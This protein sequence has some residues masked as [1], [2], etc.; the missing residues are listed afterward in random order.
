LKS[1][2]YA[3][4]SDRLFAAGFICAT[5]PTAYGGKDWTAIQSTIFAEE[6]FRAGVPTVTRGMGET[7]AGPAIMAH[8]TQEQ[9]DYFLPRIISGEDSYCQGFSEP[10]AGSDLAAVAARGVIEGDEI[11]ITGQKVWTSGF[12]RANMIFIL[13]RTDPDAPKHKGISYVLLPFTKENGIDMMPIRMITGDAEFGEEFFEGARAPLFNVIGGLNNGWTVAMG[14]LGHERTGAAT[15][16]ANRLEREFWA[17]VERARGLGRAS[18]PVV[19]QQLAWAY[20]TVQTIKYQGLRV[21]AQVATGR[22]P[23]PESSLTKVLWSEYEQRF[24]EIA[25]AIEGANALVRAPS[26]EPDDLNPGDYVLTHWQNQFLFSRS[27]TI[28]SGSSEI[29]R[30]IISER[31]L[32]M[33]R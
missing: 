24:G 23:G 27:H 15:T 9:K 11:V 6:C 32:G 20:T 12:Y 1:P 17:L 26:Q 28:Y 18:D 31:V 22:A 29:Q 14:T 16:R 3:V 8:G 2:E 33:P 30:N 21:L 5:W 25:M 4:W 13:V 19:R 7:L 10:G